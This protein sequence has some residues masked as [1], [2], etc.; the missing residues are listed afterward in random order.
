M[1][2][3]IK[4][5]LVGLGVIILRKDGKVLIGKRKGKFVPEYSI[6][7]GHLDVGETFEEGAA[8]EVKEETGM[9]VKNLKVVSVSNNLETYRKTGRHYISV[10]LLTTDFEGE[11]TIMEKNKCEEY[12]WCKPNEVPE[13]HFEA[14]KRG[15]EMYFSGKERRIG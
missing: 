1:P 11:P 14:S 8:R 10:N 7:G 4:S 15:L 5:V 3:N 6:P 12:L 9:M 13:P 2:K